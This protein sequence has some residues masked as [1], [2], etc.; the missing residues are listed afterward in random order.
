LEHC[1]CFMGLPNKI[2]SYKDHLISSSSLTHFVHESVRNNIFPS[3]IDPKINR[4]NR[5]S[6][7]DSCQCFAH[8][9]GG[10][11]NKLATGTPMGIF[12]G[13]YIRPVPYC[14]IR[15]IASFLAMTIMRSAIFSQQYRSWSSPPLRSASRRSTLCEKNSNRKSI[16]ATRNLKV[17]E[18][19]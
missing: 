11:C 6:C 12:S 15:S 16:K 19:F 9:V 14:N 8:G 10:S 3:F 2:V 18:G 17:Y 7:E 5:R 1:V 4:K 13:Q